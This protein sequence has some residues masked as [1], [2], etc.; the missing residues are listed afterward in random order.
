MIKIIDKFKISIFT[1]E[2]MLEDIKTKSSVE[3]KQKGVEE[4]F[5]KVYNSMQKYV[6]TPEQRKKAEEILKKYN[7]IQ[8]NKD[9]AEYPKGWIDKGPLDIS[10]LFYMMKNPLKINYRTD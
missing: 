10:G 2:Q 5:I 7:Q 9:D 6:H 8:V 3:I 4:K 1:L